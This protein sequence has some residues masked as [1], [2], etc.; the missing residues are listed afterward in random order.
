MDEQVNVDAIV[1]GG[2]PAGISAALTMVQKGL[3]VIVV[4]RG[5]YAGSK[6]M[7]GLIYG[8]VLEEMIPGFHKLAP[9]ERH[10]TR[11]KITFLGEGQQMSLDFGA[12]KW[13]E[14]PFN[15]TWTVHRSQFDRWFAEQAENAGA[16]LLEG[17]VVDDLSFDGSGANKAVNGVRI[18]GDENF[19]SKVVILCDGANNLLSRKT[20]VDMSMSDGIL[21]Q[22]YA[23]GVKETINLPA[24]V[25][26]DRFGLEPGQGAALDF[27]GVPFEGVIGGGF[28]YT[29]N[30]TVSL[31]F[32]ARLETLQHSKIGPN[33]LLERFKQHPEVR[34]Y[35]RGGELVEYSAHLIPE[36][37]FQAVPQLGANGLLIAGDAAGLVNMSLY[38]E[39]TNHAMASGKLAGE[40]VANAISKG[41]WDAASLKDY[42]DQLRASMTMQDL[43]KYQ[44]LPSILETTPE[45]MS[46]YP[47]KVNK[48]LVD[49]F[50]MSNQS[51]SSLQKQSLKDFFAGLSKFQ[52]VR[53]MIRARKLI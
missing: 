40:T 53:N 11:R 3:E 10:V 1:V 31:G 6:N 24:S 44:S 26:E 14:E 41:G 49:Y 21:P 33:E 8:T 36:G 28:I 52:F 15:H 19:N 51:K 7:G 50:T 34:K 32:A 23:V 29:Q 37:G 45:I 9:V 12:D 38:K 22:E 16:G 5:E 27:I 4:E 35:I 42:E 18:R 17:M 2:G 30:E 48:L 46:L 25:I 39:G 43:E 13:G 47:A 20:R